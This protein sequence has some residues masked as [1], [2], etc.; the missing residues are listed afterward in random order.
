[1]NK[2]PERKNLAYSLLLA[3]LLLFFLI[4]YFIYM[5]PSLYVDYIMDDNL[6]SIRAQHRTYVETGSYENIRV[7][8]P[9]ACFSVRIPGE[10]DSLLLS[11]KSFSVKITL[12]APALLEKFHHLQDMLNGLETADLIQ[13]LGAD[14]G[15][16]FAEWATL[17]RDS[18]SELTSS[19][20]KD[21]PVE[22]ESLQV[23]N[24]DGE[25]K[26]EYFRYHSISETLV[27]LEAGIEDD[28]NS[29]TNYIA[30]EKTDDAL[31]L[32]LLPVVTPDIRRNPPGGPAKSP[33]PCRSDPFAGAFV[34]PHLLPGDR[35][36]GPAA[37]R[38]ELSRVG[39]EKRSL[40]SGKQTP[41]NLPQSL[42]PPAKDSYIRRTP[43]GGRHD[44]ENREVQGCI[45]LPSQG[46]RASAFHEQDDRG[47]LSLKPPKRSASD[48]GP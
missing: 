26:N 12:T 34:L 2:N 43:S 31:I 46:Q 11:G 48:S 37:Y 33:C 5:I 45:A 3:G 38:P 19:S 18:M 10:G 36:S 44:Q 15:I 39:T 8:N 35:S 30:I 13:S 9:T 1:M 21:L 14:T 47:Y 16:F 22:V 4:C 25:F 6:Q 27:I 42:F 32:S 20:T 23:Q 28:N 17:F 24:L 29:Y 7:K 41:G 40:G